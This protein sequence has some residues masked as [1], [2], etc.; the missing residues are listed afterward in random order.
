MRAYGVVYR[1]F[2]DAS[3]LGSSEQARRLMH[4]D[5]SK[6]EDELA[7]VVEMWLDKMRRLHA[8][9][10]EY[11]LAGDVQAQRAEDV[12]DRQVQ[13]VFRLVGSRSR[14]L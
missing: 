6:K 7:E 13:G 2:T 8:H 11:K 9:G 10:D 1:W 5:P 14:P 12:H 4:P 3:G